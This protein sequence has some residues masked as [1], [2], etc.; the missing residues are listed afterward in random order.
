MYLKKASQLEKPYHTNKI[1]SKHK[2]NQNKIGKGME[3]VRLA[4]VPIY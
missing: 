1:P 3:A 4:M 2:A